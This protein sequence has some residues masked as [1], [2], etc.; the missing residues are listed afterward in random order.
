[1]YLISLQVYYGI[2]LN[3]GVIGGNLFINFAAAGLVECPSYILTIILF[4]YYGRRV[5]TGLYMLG[6]GVCCLAISFFSY[7][8]TNQL[9]VLIFALAGK[10]FITSTFAIIVSFS[11]RLHG[12]NPLSF[13]LQPIEFSFAIPWIHVDKS[14]NF[15]SSPTVRLLGRTISNAIATGLSRYVEQF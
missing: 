2:S 10:F 4:N 12:C 6:V 7:M 14:L 15:I 5:I 13:L 11:L 9:L 3:I 8:V 1:M